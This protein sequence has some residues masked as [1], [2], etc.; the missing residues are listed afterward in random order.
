MSGQIINGL[1]NE[2]VK[3]MDLQ[4]NKDT[5][6]LTNRQANEQIKQGNWNILQN[7]DNKFFTLRPEKTTTNSWS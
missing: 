4:M 2:E 3:R 1:S 5:S 7:G 6:K